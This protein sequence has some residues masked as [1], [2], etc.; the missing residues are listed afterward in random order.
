MQLFATGKKAPEALLIK[1]GRSAFGSTTASTPSPHGMEPRG[2]AGRDLRGLERYDLLV[3]PT[4]CAG[5]RR[6]FRNMN[7]GVEFVPA[8]STVSSACSSIRRARGGDRTAGSSAMPD[9]RRDPVS[10]APNTGLVKTIRFA[11]P[12]PG[13]PVKIFNDKEADELCLLTSRRRSRRGPSTCSGISSEC[14]MPGYGGG[15]RRWAGQAV[16]SV[17]VEGHLNSAV[18]PSR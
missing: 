6:Q 3:P 14:Y 18:V 1:R 17:G 2:S 10:P 16:T 13:R 15:I 4:T 7:T 12:P 9:A 5:E 11:A 8:I